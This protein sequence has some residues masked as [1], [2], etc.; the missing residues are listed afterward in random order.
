LLRQAAAEALWQVEGGAD[1]ALKILI[2]DASTRLIGFQPG[3]GSTRGRAALALGRIGPPAKAAIPGLQDLLAKGETLPDRLDAAEALWR[4]TSD[5]KPLLPLITA[6]LKTEL[7][8]SGDPLRGAPVDKSA[9]ARA[10]A[11]LALM[12]PAARDAAPALAA[13]IRAEDE[14]N[15]RQ[16]GFIRPLKHDE[17]DEDPDTMN[18][19]RR[20]GLPVLER[21]DPALATALAAPAKTP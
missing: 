12:G 17:E 4:L 15:A 8:G 21:L 20:V 3:R 1:D 16:K 5:V 13:A 11:V 10:I 7:K 19:I 14:F 2:A 9:H 18:L 6:V